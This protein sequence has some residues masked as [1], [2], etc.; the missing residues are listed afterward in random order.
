MHCPLVAPKCIDF[1]WTPPIG[2]TDGRT[3]KSTDGGTRPFLNI[4]GA[5]TDWHKAVTNTEMMKGFVTIVLM[6]LSSVLIQH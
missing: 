4:H 2:E 6:V 1:R 3:L 5:L